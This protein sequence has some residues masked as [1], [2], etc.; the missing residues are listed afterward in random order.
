MPA[1]TVASTTTEVRQPGTRL[2]GLRRS[3]RCWSLS[4]P[5]SHGHLLLE[6]ILLLLFI[7]KLHRA[8]STRVSGSHE[9][10]S[11]FLEQLPGARGCLSC[12]CD[13]SH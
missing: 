3:P 1:T 2:A 11:D 4:S 7:Q 6:V 9:Q 13:R 8:H 5:Q 10:F 12:P